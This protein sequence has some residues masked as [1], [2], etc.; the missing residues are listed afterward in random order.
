MYAGKGPSERISV[1]LSSVSGACSPGRGLSNQSRRLTDGMSTR[2]PRDPLAWEGL[3]TTRRCGHPKSR[4][5]AASASASVTSTVSGCGTRS[6]LASRNVAALSDAHSTP[7]NGPA[8]TGTGKSS[9]A[10]AQATISEEDVGKT[11]SAASSAV[12]SRIRGMNAG[13]S[14]K[15]T[16]SKA[17]QMRPAIERGFASVPTTA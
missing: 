13:S 7:S 8:I 5:A 16:T 10:R 12:T 1:T 6:C 14:P 3:I 4:A 15:G 2:I 17:S 11:T 9:R